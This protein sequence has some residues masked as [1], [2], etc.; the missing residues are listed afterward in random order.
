[1]T[2]HLLGAGASKG[3]VTDLLADF[4]TETVPYFNAV[5]VIRDKFL[6]GDP[7]DVVILSAALLDE[8]GKRGLLLEGSAAPIGVVRTGVA[9]PAG[10]PEPVIATSEALR[11]ALLA[12]RGLYLPDPEGST[13]GIHVMRVLRDLGIEQAVRPY[14]RPFANGA[15]AMRHLT[16]AP[17]ENPIGITQITEIKYSPGLTLIGPLPEAHG[18]STVYAAAVAA[19]SAQ[20]DA[21]RALVV[22]LTGPASSALRTASGFET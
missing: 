11:T 7:C 18:L 9:V 16:E 10:H 21:A 13:A 19:R 17:E 4:A 15:V 20:P 12:S 22:R 14:L 3:L 1:M 2:L 6:A 8:L 5:G